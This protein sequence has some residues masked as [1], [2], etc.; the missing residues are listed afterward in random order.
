MKTSQHFLKKH[1]LA[2]SM[3]LLLAS[4]GSYMLT[5]SPSFAESASTAPISNTPV[6]VAGTLPS[7]ATMI[8]KNRKAVV[9]ISVTGK[10][11]KL[12][13]G[14]QFS[15]NQLPKEFRE[16]FKDHPNMPWNN[17][18]RKKHAQG[19]GFIISNDGYI[20]TNAHVVDN[21]S[22][23]TVR[24]DDKRKFD[25]KVIGVDKLS[26][27]AL[28]KIDTSGLPYVSLGDSDKL[29][30]GQWV[31]AIGA[32]FGLDYT[33]TQGIVSALSRSLPTETYVPFIQTDAAINPGNSGGPLFDLKG[34]VIGVN[35]QIYSKSGG[36]MGV[37][38][39]IP[40]NI[41]KNV[42]DQLKNTGKVSRGW[43]GVGIQNVSQNLAQSFNMSDTN[44]S[45][46]SSVVK[47]SPA[48]KAG[49]AV[50][51]V[52]ISYDDKAVESSSHLPLLVGNTPI[53]KDVV[54]KVIRSGVEKQL[55]VTINK[56]GGSD[57]PVVAALDK[58]SLG[59]A[60]SD[61]S[62]E[63][64]AKLNNKNQGV[65]IEN[66]MSDSPADNAGIQSGDVI[67]TVDGKS[68][69]SPATLKKVIQNADAKKPLAI[70]LQRGDQ[71]LFVAVRLDS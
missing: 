56:L 26:D 23:I 37:S 68:I 69:E 3:S 48:E 64:R 17:Q 22:K 55:N 34:N 65:K 11:P 47:D 51:D 24:L 15:Q 20:V 7:L 57:E 18:Q 59:V 35:S 19:S 41:V 29:D 31:V 12:G 40:I 33:A 32:P 8:K 71:A 44:G 52:I 54:I 30:V 42:T 39:A 62:K 9:N 16:F 13:Q 49:L 14:Q 10:K 53:G 67:L 4:M 43:L 70:L 46:V 45:L 21:S 27:I 28:I 50:G 36:Y 61:L 25:A 2:I 66:V 6:T 58:G 63:E 38:F 1:K 5:A 60:V